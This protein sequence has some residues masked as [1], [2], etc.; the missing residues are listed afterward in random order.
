ML[1]VSCKTNSI[2][3]NKSYNKDDYKNV[4]IKELIK[5]PDLFNGKKIRVDGFF[6]YGLEQS[7]ISSNRKPEI[8]KSIWV[9]FDFFKSLSNKNNENLLKDDKLFD[10]SKNKIVIKGIYSTKFNG[11]LG[12]YKGSI[13]EISYFESEEN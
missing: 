9:K 11:H 12:L 10:Y 1:L 2:F 7:S 5:T 13:K 4:S 3:T 6:F 8:G